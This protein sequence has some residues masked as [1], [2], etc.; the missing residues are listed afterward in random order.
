MLGPDADHRVARNEV[1]ARAADKLRNEPIRG[2]V[3]DLR[4]RPDLAYLALVHHY[5]PVGQAHGFF[6]VV[7][8][9]DSGHLQFLLLF[10]YELAHREALIAVQRAQRLVH[11]IHRRLP[12]HGACQR[13]PLLVAA[14]EL[15][16]KPVELPG[17]PESVRHAIQGFPY[18]GVGSARRAQREDDVLAHRQVRVQGIELEHKANVTL[19]RPEPGDIAPGHR[20]LARRRHFQTSDHAQR[21][22]LPAS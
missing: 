14:A 9:I 11:E 20:H 2:I 1:H 17:Q 7:R 5:D 8:N 4:R 16:R 10:P 15:G 18:R 19:R 6:L 3:I 22:R 21:G 12:Y 13:Y